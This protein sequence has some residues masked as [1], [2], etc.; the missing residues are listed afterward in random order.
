MS[1]TYNVCPEVHCMLVTFNV[2]VIDWPSASQHGPC[3]STRDGMCTEKDTADDRGF[4]E[5]LLADPTFLVK[6]GIE[7]RPSRLTDNKCTDG[8]TRILSL[9]CIGS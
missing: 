2:D 4:R 5:R 3:I 7:V 1:G 8:R 9:S 6:V